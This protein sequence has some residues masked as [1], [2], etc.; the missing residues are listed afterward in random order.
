MEVV[1]HLAKPVPVALS[2][3]PGLEAEI[4]KFS[5]TLGFTMVL[6]FMFKSKS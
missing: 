3:G 5:F 6:D 4:V 2:M 1:S